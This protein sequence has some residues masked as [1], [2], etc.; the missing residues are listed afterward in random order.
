MPQPLLYDISGLD[1]DRPQFTREDIDRVNPQRHE[2]CQLDSIVCL[3]PEEKISVGVRDLREDEFWV[4]GH[5]P[6][7]PIFPG[8]LMLEAAAQLCSFYTRSC[9]EHDDI[10]G[11]GGAN[12]VRF[13]RML[14]VGDRLVLLARPERISSRRSL[15]QVQGLLEGELAFEAKILGIALPAKTPS[16]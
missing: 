4:R 6:G 5:M 10:F 8:V 11:F 12:E 2:F 15:Y 9:L 16:E 14:T 13:R 3:L 1:L 7:Q